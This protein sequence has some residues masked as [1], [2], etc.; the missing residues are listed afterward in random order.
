MGQAGTKVAGLC[1]EVGITR[2]TLYRFVGPKGELGPDAEKL[3]ARR[4]RGIRFTETMDSGP[5]SVVIE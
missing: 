5:Q 3:L 2:Q 4:K 1:A